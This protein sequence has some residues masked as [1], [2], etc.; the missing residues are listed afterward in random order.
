MDRRWNKEEDWPKMIDFLIDTSKRKEKTVKN[1]VKKLN[2][3]IRE[4]II[5]K[6]HAIILVTGEY[7][8]K[9]TQ[10]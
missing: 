7:K 3:T 5:K 2:T 1:Y 4:N 9:K 6:L 10:T 8:R